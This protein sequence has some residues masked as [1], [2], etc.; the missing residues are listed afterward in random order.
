M[1]LYFY[2][3][4]FFIFKHF[5]RSRS[6]VSHDDDTKYNRATLSSTAKVDAEKVRVGARERERSRE[7][8]RE[9]NVREK[10]VEGRER[11]GER[12]RAKEY[13]RVREDRD[14]EKGKGEDEDGEERRRGRGRERSRDG[15]WAGRDRSEMSISSYKTSKSG[16]RGRAQSP[17]WTKLAAESVNDTTNNNVNRNRNGEMYRRKSSEL[18]HYIASTPPLLRFPSENKDNIMIN[19]DTQNYFHC[20]NSAEIPRN[21]TSVHENFSKSRSISRSMSISMSRDTI[22][23]GTTGTGYGIRTGGRVGEREVR[24]GGGGG[25]EEVEKERNNLAL[26][27]QKH[28]QGRKGANKIGRK[29]FSDFGYMDKI[30]NENGKLEKKTFS[31][32][33]DEYSKHSESRVQVPSSRLSESNQFQQQ[34]QQQ[35]QQQQEQTEILKSR[36]TEG[37]TKGSY[38]KNFFARSFSPVSTRSNTRVRSVSPLN[39]S[40]MSNMSSN[41]VRENVKRLADSHRACVMTSP[42]ASNQRRHYEFD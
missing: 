16:I 11:R 32:K 21:S 35:Q 17:N 4:L 39:I 20:E 41:K 36:S 12:E 1:F 28:P 2:N 37:R 31:E 9:K 10:S 30:I 23:T 8:I 19:S 40:M 13:E 14:K 7:S 15:D 29:G 18:S 33:D 6:A 26:S 3:K 22:M 42:A 38:F 5:R 27:L 25:G 34:L 24:G